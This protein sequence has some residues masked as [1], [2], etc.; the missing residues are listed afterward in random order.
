MNI[1]IIGCG[2]IAERHLAAYRHLGVEVTVYDAD[3]SASLRRS[4][5]FGVGYKRTLEEVLESQVD[6][7]DVCVPT[8]WHKEIVAAALEHDKHVFCEKPLCATLA[9]AG[10]IAQAL[11]T[12]RRHLMVGYLY[13][14]HPA[15]A[16]VQQLLEDE[17]I[18]QPYF[19]LLRLGG[20]GDAA[21]WKHERA[22]GGGAL[23]EMMVHQLDLAHWFFG[24]LAEP[25]LLFQRI[26]LPERIVNSAS[27]AADAE[28]CVVA[29]LRA[30]QV[31]ALIEADLATPS[32]MNHVEIQ[33][34]NG[35]V[36][37]SMLHYLPTQVYC[38]DPRGM[39]DRG[40]TLRNFPAVNLFEKELGHFLAVIRG[41]CHAREDIDVSLNMLG[42]LDE[43]RRQAGE[44]PSE[45]RFEDLKS[46]VSGLPA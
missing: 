2:K 28:D 43:L 19:S 31:Q 16:Y 36:F 35:S 30:G 45:R 41:E 37:C 7:I 10:E 44:Q 46:P 24:A 15:F 20:R 38:K 27:V 6:A 34:T 9:E 26:L 23:L 17:T 18:G 33:A 29:S 25:R 11:S 12:H 13:R 3:P 42:V 40:S 39:F 5:E 14:F 1:G 32:Y 4:A 8:A 22:A 21:A